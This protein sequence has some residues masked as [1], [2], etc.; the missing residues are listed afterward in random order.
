MPA[1]TE[2]VRAAWS[3]FKAPP[4]L[5]EQPRRQD[6]TARA[7]ADGRF[8]IW[9]QLRNET[10]AICFAPAFNEADTFLRFYVVPWMLGKPWLSHS[11]W[12]G[13]PGD[14][15]VTEHV[16]E[17]MPARE[18]HSVR[19]QAATAE[20]RDQLDQR[21]GAMLEE[22]REDARRERLGLGGERDA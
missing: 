5:G 10:R 8:L 12:G 1:L 22:A 15:A 20:Q 21:L 7:F 6:I 19:I 14:P 11:T 9:F 17:I 16:I 18:L 4:A 13:L 3:A 2:R